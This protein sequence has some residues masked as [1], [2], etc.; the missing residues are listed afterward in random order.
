MR[1]VLIVFI[2]LVSFE[3][4]AQKSKV[5]LKHANRVKGTII[6]G[7]SVNKLYGKV[8]LKKDNVDFYCDS[9]IRYNNL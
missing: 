2:L 4:T 5:R 7:E 8:H 6:N 1:I 3:V 9:A